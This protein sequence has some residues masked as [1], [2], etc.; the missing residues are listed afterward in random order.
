[1][2][3]LLDEKNDAL[4]DRLAELLAGQVCG[5]ESPPIIGDLRPAPAPI[6]SDDE[7][8]EE[9]TEDEPAEDD[10]DLDEEDLEVEDEEEEEFDEDDFDD[11]FDDDFEEDVDESSESDHAADLPRR[12]RMTTMR[13]WKRN[14]RTT[15]NRPM[16]IIGGWSCLFRGEERG[17]L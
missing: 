15:F 11:E 9:E 5:G 6:L 10:D 1:M 16:D 8:D 17:K 3:V 13:N 4:P 2:T 12:T 7:D 14:S